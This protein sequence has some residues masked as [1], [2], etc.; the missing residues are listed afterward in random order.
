MIEDEIARKLDKLLDR[1]DSLIELW[2]NFVSK[3]QDEQ[4]ERL[5]DKYVHAI[6]EGVNKIADSINGGIWNGNNR[7]SDDSEERLNKFLDE[8][9]DRKLGKTTHGFILW[10]LG[11]FGTGVF[12]TLVAVIVALLTGH[13]K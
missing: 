2:A 11:A 3:R 4:D 6:K 5:E 7:R 1:L 10:I 9:D 12:T 8:R 13:W